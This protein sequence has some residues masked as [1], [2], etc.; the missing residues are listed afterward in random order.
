VS[1]IKPQPGNPH[2]LTLW[3][4]VFP[5]K[6]IGRFAG[7]DGRVAVR[8]CRTKRQF[9][10]APEDRFFCAQ[11]AWDQR[12]EAGY[13]KGIENAFQTVADQII[14]GLRTIDCEQSR[15]VTKF[16]ALW[17]LRFEQ[18]H[19][20]TPDHLING[21]AP[22]H[23]SRDQEEM[24]E[25][26]WVSFVGADRTMSGRCVAGL[27]IQ[28][29]IA[30]ADAQFEG[31]RWGVLTASDGEFF[32]PDTFGRMTIV[33]VT[34]SICL[35]C[36]RQDEIISRKEVSELNNIARHSAWDYYFARDFTQCP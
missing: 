20:P 28:V 5:S 34:P 30:Q 17:F 31:T 10:L 1:A 9:W 25:S 26:N 15:I 18:R 6:S 7:S 14:R 21:I 35:V 12:A 13:M 32:V 3:Q 22:E 16:F 11:R 19:R 24:L 2:G 27:Q 8:R 36:T 33:P 4:H 29:K 23:L